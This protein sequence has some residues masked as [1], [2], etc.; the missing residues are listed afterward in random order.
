MTLYRMT[1]LRAGKPKGTTF[2]ARNDQAALNLAEKWVA[3]FG[4]VLL[5]AGFLRRCK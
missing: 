1:Y 2:A 3:G 4:G 5:T